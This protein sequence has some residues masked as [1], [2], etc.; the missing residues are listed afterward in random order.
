MTDLDDSPDESEGSDIYF[1]CVFSLVLDLFQ[2]FN[3]ILDDE[4]R[5]QYRC[6]L[7]KR[8]CLSYLRFIYRLSMEKWDLFTKDSLAIGCVHVLRRKGA[9][10][11]PN[12][13]KNYTNLTASIIKIN[14][15]YPSFDFQM[16]EFL[17][18]SLK[19]IQEF[20]P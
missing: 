13:I 17:R 14:H 11:T 1:L 16:L 2:H 3:D 20:G 18:A 12:I 15:I 4:V 5:W 9:K 10:R 8:S 19:F 6:T 7:Q